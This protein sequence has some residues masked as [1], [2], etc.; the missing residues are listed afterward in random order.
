MVDLPEPE[1]TSHAKI[2]Y[3]KDAG[4]KKVVIPLFKKYITDYFDKK[5]INA[6]FET[7]KRNKT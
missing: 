5:F 6:Y 7:K 2:T 3:K 1:Y 4:K